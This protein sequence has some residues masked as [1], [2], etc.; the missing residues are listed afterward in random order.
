MLGGLLGT[1]LLLGG[2]SAPTLLLGVTA[3]T[4]L[5]L[6]VEREVGSGEVPVGVVEVG[7]FGGVGVFVEGG[8]RFGSEVDFLLG[9]LL[10]LLLLLGGLGLGGG[11]GP[12]IEAGFLAAGV[13]GGGLEAGGGPVVEA[14]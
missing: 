8:D 6:G 9:G 10:L 11:G 5:L 7:G 3:P 4:L 14:G 12:V 13:L 1:P 2:L